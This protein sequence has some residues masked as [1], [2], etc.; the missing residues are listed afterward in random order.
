[1]DSIAYIRDRSPDSGW[2]IVGWPLS[3]NASGNARGPTA[4]DV[5]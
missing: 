2:L 5:R 3:G 1:M 4:T